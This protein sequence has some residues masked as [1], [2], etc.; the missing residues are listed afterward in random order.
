MFK[1]YEKKAYAILVSIMILTLISFVGCDNITTNAE[2]QESNTRSGVKTVRD[3]DGA[4]TWLITLDNTQTEN[5]LSHY[6]RL[7]HQFV[8]NY[9]DINL[10]TLKELS[11]FITENIGEYEQVDEY[12]PIR[13]KV[14]I[15]VIKTADGHQTVTLRESQ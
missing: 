8:A 9:S 6:E 15:V 1:I 2:I 13:E 3:S 7:I 5:G 10:M 12:N 14:T 11:V 4:G